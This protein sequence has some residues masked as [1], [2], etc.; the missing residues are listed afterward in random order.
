MRTMAGI[1]HPGEWRG[2]SPPSLHLLGGLTPR[3]S[4]SIHRWWAASAATTFALTI[5][6]LRSTRT[7]RVVRAAV[8]FTTLALPPSLAAGSS[9][10]LVAG[11]RL[12]VRGEEH[13]R[14][15]HNFIALGQ[16]FA[17]F[18]DLLVVKAESDWVAFIPGWC[19]DEDFPLG[20]HL[21]A[22]NDRLHRHGKN[23]FLG[24][25]HGDC[26][27]GCHIRFQELALNRIVGAVG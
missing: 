1:V 17:N 12:I 9:L 5:A 10:A 2:V 8:P 6:T 14:I 21:G 23:R 11:S 19:L 26:H 25:I 18:N 20:P 13:L 27:L 15:E 3:R 22:T 4:P 24:R 16:P 7:L